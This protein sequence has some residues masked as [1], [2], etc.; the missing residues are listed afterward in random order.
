MIRVENISKYFGQHKVLDNINTVFEE[1]KCNLIIGKSGSGKTVLMKCLVGL[2][3]PDEGY[4]G[5]TFVENASRDHDPQNT[6]QGHDDHRD[7]QRIPNRFQIQ[8]IL[9]DIAVIVQPHKR[10]GTEAKIEKTVIKSFAH[11]IQNM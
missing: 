3:Y 5:G 8:G 1:G 10:N 7:Q 9:Q 4:I 2:I 11:R 6:Q